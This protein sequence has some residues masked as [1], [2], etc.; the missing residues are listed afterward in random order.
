MT[1]YFKACV[2]I[3]GLSAFAVAA[4]QLGIA[5]ASPARVLQRAATDL[6]LKIDFP[7]TQSVRGRRSLT[8]RSLLETDVTGSR[9]K[10]LT[11]GIEAKV[12]HGANDIS[13]VL[14]EP[15]SITF[16]SEAARKSGVDRGDDFTVVRNDDSQLVAYLF[17]GTSLNSFVLNKTNGLA[18]WSKIRSTFPVYDA[19]TGGTSYLL[20]R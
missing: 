14:K 17:N 18:I 3:C 7:P 20:C 9:D 2:A 19:P 15:T 16:I 5:H 11:N 6:T 13:I 4:G 10:F 1:I 8:C 12:S